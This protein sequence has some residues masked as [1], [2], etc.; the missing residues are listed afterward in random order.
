MQFERGYGHVTYD[1]ETKKE[2]T[3]ILIEEQ[4]TSLDRWLEYFVSED[5]KHYPMWFKYYVFQNVFEEI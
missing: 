2:E 1:D 3:N 4:K 5:T